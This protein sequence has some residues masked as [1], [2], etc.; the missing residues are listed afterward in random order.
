M[1]VRLEYARTGL[2]VELPADRVV[3][4]LAYKDVEPLADPQAAMAEV[5]AATTRATIDGLAPG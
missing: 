1:R 2:E 5:L 3:R 4:K